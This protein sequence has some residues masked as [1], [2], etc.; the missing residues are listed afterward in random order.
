MQKLQ[1]TDVFVVG[2]GPAGLAAALAARKKGF[3]VAVADCARP[4]IDKACGEGLMPDAVAILSR[5]GVSMALEEAYPLRGIRFIEGETS[6]ESAF[7]SGIG[8]GIRR[9]SLHRILIQRACEAGVSI[10]WGAH[11]DGPCSGGVV[12]DGSAIR[13]RWI[14]GA[15]GQN[16][17]VRRWAGLDQPGSGKIRFGYRRHFHLKPWTDCVEVHWGPGCQIVITPVGSAEVGVALLS[18]NPRLRLQEA[19]P[20]FPEIGK[21][22]KEARPIT[23]ERGAITL[24]RGLPAVWRGQFALIGDASGSV[25]AITGEG[26]CLAFQQAVWLAEGLAGNDLGLYQAAHRRIARLPALMSWLMLSID[27]H[28]SLRHSVLRTFAAYP[29]IFSRFLAIHLGAFPVKPGLPM[30]LQPDSEISTPIPVS[31]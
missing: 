13:C 30:A 23:S 18:R 5:L 1:E 26:L 3:R 20:L 29:P 8:L 28:P 21:R 16:S 22:L 17:L 6:V 9:T 24:R 19:L 25:D 10:Y 11:V 7:P 12:L 2:G 14:I 27:R 31:Q 15:D 4:P